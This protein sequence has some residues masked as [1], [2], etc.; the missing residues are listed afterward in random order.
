RRLTLLIGSAFL[1]CPNKPLSCF[2]VYKHRMK[3]K[4]ID[5]R[6][7]DEDGLYIFVFNRIW[8]SCF[9]RGDDDCLYELSPCRCYMDGIFHFCERENRV[10]F[11]A[12]RAF[13]HGICDLSL[14]K[15]TLIFTSFIFFFFM[16]VNIYL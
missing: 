16:M 2:F 8:T 10:L 15:Q 12:G 13:N 5:K 14:S 11:F 1:L 9:R 7:W 3:T 4:L 6:G